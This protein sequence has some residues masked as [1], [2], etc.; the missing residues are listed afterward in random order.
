MT[1]HNRMLAELLLLISGLPALV[2]EAVS[3]LDDDEEAEVLERI[4]PDAEA[5]GAMLADSDALPF[6][7]VGNMLRRL[8]DLVDLSPATAAK[9]VRYECIFRRCRDADAHHQLFPAR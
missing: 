4:L 2:R 1:A 7:P 9:L 3:G 8:R 6:Q 5:A